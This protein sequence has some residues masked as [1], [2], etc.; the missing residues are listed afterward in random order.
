[1]IALKTNNDNIRC[2]L[3]LNLNHEDYQFLYVEDGVAHMMSM[4]SYEELEL[5]VSAC[6]GGD[7]ALAL[8]EGRYSFPQKR[9]YRIS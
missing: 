3:V 6:E 5:P 7:E 4:E 9:S 1:M 8:L 2:Y